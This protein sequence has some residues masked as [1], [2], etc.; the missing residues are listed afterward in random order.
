[1]VLATMVDIMNTTTA[2]RRLYNS[3]RYILYRPLT[4]T[5][6][7]FRYR[8]KGCRKFY[9]LQARNYRE[10]N[11]ISDPPGRKSANLAYGMDISMQSWSSALKKTMKAVVSPSAIDLSYKIFLR[12]N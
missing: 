11:F 12:Q 6:N 1:M 9:L 4:V 3:Y 8:S 10:S 2:D 5:Q 7:E